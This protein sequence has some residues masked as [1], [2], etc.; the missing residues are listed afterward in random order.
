MICNAWVLIKKKFY[1]LSD[2]AAK[3]A[4]GLAGCGDIFRNY[5]AIFLGGFYNN[6]GNSFALHAELVGVMITIETV[7]VRG[8]TKHWIERDSMLVIKAFKTSYVIHCK[9]R[10]RWL[11]CIN[12]AH[13]MSFTLS[14]IY[15]EDNFCADKLTSHDSFT[16]LVWW[17]SLLFFYLR[18]VF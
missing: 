1:Q 10:N 7:V 15:C 14:H 3:G 2:G 16:L 5:R 4:P 11:N 17:D 8:W 6:L 13:S 9:L 12:M 18:G